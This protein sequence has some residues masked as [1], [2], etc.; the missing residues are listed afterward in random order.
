[1]LGNPSRTLRTHRESPVFVD[2]RVILILFFLIHTY[3]Q[4]SYVLVNI[5]F[6]IAPNILRSILDNPR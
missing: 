5:V 4:R 1:M 6:N 2:L 3:M